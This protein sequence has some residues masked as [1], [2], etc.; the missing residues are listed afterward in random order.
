MS[1]C[2]ESIKSFEIV[3]NVVK[4]K[5]HN[6]KSFWGCNSYNLRQQQANSLIKAN[7]SKDLLKKSQHRCGKND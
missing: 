7:A 6:K 1:Q 5:M 4:N 2:F 3:N